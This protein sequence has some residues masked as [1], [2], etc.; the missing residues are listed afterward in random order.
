MQLS[1]P[2][3]QLGQL[4]LA[5]GMIDLNRLLDCACRAGAHGSASLDELLVES[6][7]LKPSQV[8][9]LHRDLGQMDDAELQ[10]VFDQGDTIA[11]ESVA[12]NSR[13]HSRT[14]IDQYADSIAVAQ[15]VQTPPPSEQSDDA[16]GTD[17]QTVISA[18][19][20]PTR[21]YDII[22]ELGRG[23]MGKILRA[24]DQLLDRQI[25]LKTLLPD[26]SVQNP[27]QRLVAEARLTGR[28]EHPSIV[29]VYELGD[30]PGEE[31]YYTMRVVPEHS[32]RATIDELGDD[33]GDAPSMLR[34]AQIL[35][36]VCLAVQFAHEKGVVHRDLKP[37]NIL[38]GKYGEVF[39]IDWGIAKVLSR[40]EGVPSPTTADENA[41][42]SVVGTPQYMAPEQARGDHDNIDER[43]D[44]YALGAI[45]Y[46]LLTLTPVFS[47]KHV[48]GLLLSTIQDPPDPPS[49]RAPRRS[50][51][52]PLEEICLQAIS[53]EPADRYP[54][55]KALADELGL[56]IEGV[57]DR[58]RNEER[59]RELIDEARRARDDYRQSKRR[60]EQAVEERNELRTSTPG[61]ADEEQRSELWELEDR[62]EDLEIEVEREFG[63]TTRLLGQSLGHHPLDEAHDALA[64]MYW[65]RFVQAERRGD[66]QMAAHFENLV[67]Q[68]DTGAF[69]DRLDGRAHL[70]IE[71]DP[72]HTEL[73]LTRIEEHHRRL[74][75][76][77]AV[78]TSRN[79]LSI[80]GLP[81]GRYRI[82]AEADGY[83]PLQLPVEL[84]RLED[85]TIEL[86]MWPRDAVPE[87]LVVIP[88]GPFR[89]GPPDEF[90]MESQTEELPSF[91]IQR[92][93]VTCGE[94]L[95]F[96]NDLAADDLAH[97][98]QYA[99]RTRDDAESYF[100]IEDGQ[101]T[102]PESDPEGDAWEMD[103][104][105]FIVNY[106]DAKAYAQWRSQRDG[107]DYRLPTNLEWEKAARGTDGRLYPWGSHFDPSF[108]RMRD[109][110]AD[111]P[112]PAPVGD[113]DADFSP[114]GVYDMAGNICEWT[115]SRDFDSP[116]D[117][118]LCGGS[119]DSIALACRLHWYQS[120][121]PLFRH[122]H[123]GFRLALDLGDRD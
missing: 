102:L 86:K 115:C 104:P 29:P 95:E 7:I 26:T 48:M 80:E 101:F 25:A 21:R 50:I 78:A 30:L 59:A 107:H 1:D 32:L 46:E 54:S 73:R 77:Q 119:Y 49:E 84:E 45:L 72:G 111:K 116:E 2:E 42:G 23:G 92:T 53:K 68:H 36:Q 11:L 22:D 105:I 55:A 123:Y 83:V 67:R 82:N 24:H 96:L 41:A 57:K 10:S 5:R 69:V 61:W 51:P 65:Q 122:G 19:R 120:S 121:P 13:R 9:R 108:C 98:R 63:R 14:L 44:I 117:Y 81:H 97:A 85:R 109:S 70:C 6:G 88:A 16:A 100:P 60:L 66:R 75:E 34:L 99:P 106:H 90:G 58:E 17:T 64:S 38:L 91:A 39:V 37:E 79:T 62:V 74:V 113:Y 28:L 56:Y 43:A 3:F 47:S 76:Q 33:D 52:E 87:D 31:P 93:P 12:E 15:T 40:A 112:I 89:T 110:N 35:R 27:K 71:A 114:Y 18:L 103:W 8:E 20:D 118:I 4:A 94:Y